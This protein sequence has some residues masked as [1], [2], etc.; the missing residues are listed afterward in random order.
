VDVEGTIEC[1]MPIAA[2]WIANLN[3]ENRQP[4]SVK[5]GRL[6]TISCAAYRI[7]TLKLVPQQG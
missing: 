1:G 5:G 4:L 7:V 2:A 3:E 6:L